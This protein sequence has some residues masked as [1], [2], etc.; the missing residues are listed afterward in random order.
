MTKIQIAEMIGLEIIGFKPRAATDG[1]CGALEPI[2]QLACLGIVGTEAEI[3][4]ALA[5]RQS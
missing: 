2:W 5:L 3:L 1:A 4:A